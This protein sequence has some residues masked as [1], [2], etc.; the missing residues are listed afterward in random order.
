MSDTID[1]FSMLADITMATTAV[2]AAF[3]ANDWLKNKGLDNA[4]SFFRE[5]HDLH[6]RYSK[7]LRYAEESNRVFQNQEGLM[8]PNP[9]IISNEQFWEVKANLYKTKEEFD[10]FV[11]SYLLM[12]AMDIKLS[13]A[14]AELVEKQMNA[15]SEFWAKAREFNNAISEIVRRGVLSE[16]M[17]RVRDEVT[18]RYQMVFVTLDSSMDINAELK[19]IKFKDFY[20]L[21]NP[22]PFMRIYDA[23]S[24][25]MVRLKERLCQL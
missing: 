22:R 15:H 12:D 11:S 6:K 7:I 5:V 24:G 2:W 25:L 17:Q 23:M 3:K 21:S 13:P 14:S 18:V 20:T 1:F 10:H 9:G 16:D 19:K 8:S 4:E